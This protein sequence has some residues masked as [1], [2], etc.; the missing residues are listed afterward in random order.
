MWRYYRNQHHYLYILIKINAKSSGSVDHTNR[1]GLAF[2]AGR[3]LEG[4]QHAIIYVRK[5]V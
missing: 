3:S 1:R 4:K 2:P 5:S